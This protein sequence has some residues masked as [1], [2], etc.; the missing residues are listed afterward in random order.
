[1][2]LSWST[3][4][5]E[6][7]NF[8]VLVWILKRFLFAPV[9]TIVAHRRAAIEKSLDDARTLRAEADAL[10]QQYQG[11]LADWERERQQAR[12]TLDRELETERGRRLTALQG[13]LE[14]EREKAR[15]TEA[16]RRTDEL[17]RLEETALQQACAFATRLLRGGAG[18]ETEARLVEMAVRELRRLPEA[19]VEALRNGF[20]A[21]H[22]V[23]V[24]SAFPLSEHQRRELEGALAPLIP[25]ALPFRYAQQEE[26]LAG[27]R[28]T[29][30]AWILGANLRDELR[31]FAKLARDTSR[32]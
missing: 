21:Q 30:G 8:L 15:V 18:P 16:R 12:E 24:I 32:L 13:T 20:A 3:F 26:L 1:L 27:L 14:E 29:L 5:L 11:R 17:Q 22:Q 19:R 10:A 31:G 7:I 9:R 25:P 2:E 4:L 6:I 28:I 23:E